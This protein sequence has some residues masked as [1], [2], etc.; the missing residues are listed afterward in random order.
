MDQHPPLFAQAVTLT[1]PVFLQ[2]VPLQ[3]LGLFADSDNHKILAL[4]T[5]P[6]GWLTRD[7]GGGGE[8]SIRLRREALST[9]IPTIHETSLH[10]LSIVFVSVLGVT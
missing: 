5:G 3:S 8:Y 9:I 10:G 2:Y 4:A 7:R 6:L 1:P